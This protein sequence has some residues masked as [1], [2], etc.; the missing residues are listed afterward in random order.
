MQAYMDEIYE[1]FK[2]HVVAIRGKKLKKQIDELAGGRVYTG[3][4]ALE[5]GLVD[6]IGTLEDAVQFVAREAKLADYDVRVVPK[7]K[8]FL[9]QLLEEL[10]G[11]EKEEGKGLDARAAALVRDQSSVLEM[12]LPH[13]KHLDPQRLAAVKQ[14][15]WRLELI[16]KEGVVLMMPEI[17]LGR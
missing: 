4:Q 10:T 7:P 3:Q 14:A 12:A 15:L 11:E 5:L 16:R 1:V 13:L 8:N 6:K 9:E 17:V 2:G